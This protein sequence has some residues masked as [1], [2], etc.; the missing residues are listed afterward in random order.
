MALS[1]LS[2]TKSWTSAA[3][4]PTIEENETQV[5]ADM[6]ELHDQAKAYLNGTLTEELDAALAELAST[7][8]VDG[9]LAAVE[10]ALGGKASV[11]YAQEM[12]AAAA[13]A[14]KTELNA[15]LATRATIDYVDAKAQ[16]LVLEGLEA[17]VLTPAEVKA[18]W[19][20]TEA[21]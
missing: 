6:Q 17:A 3:D 13:G 11:A 16:S 7:D 18:L 10:T 21:E 5:R 12:A 9:Q 19:D 1:K 20:G 8:Y 4:F 2:F 15:A 14:V